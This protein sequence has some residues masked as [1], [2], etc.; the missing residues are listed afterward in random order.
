MTLPV[1]HGTG[2]RSEQSEGTTTKS[3]QNPT[4]KGS[5]SMTFPCLHF[6]TRV[7]DT[8]LW[9]PICTLP[10]EIEAQELNADC[11]IHLRCQ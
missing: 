11:Q 10:K 1:S 9:F 3:T 6:L 4:K 5:P 2:D 7:S 8:G